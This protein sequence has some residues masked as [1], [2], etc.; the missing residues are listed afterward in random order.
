MKDSTNFLKKKWFSIWFYQFSKIFRLNKSFDNT[1]FQSTIFFCMNNFSFILMRN[2]WLIHKRSPFFSSKNRK[3][4]YSQYLSANSN[5]YCFVSFFKISFFQSS[6]SPNMKSF[7]S[8][9]FIDQIFW[10]LRLYAVKK[11]N[12]SQICSQ[13][14]T[15]SESFFLTFGIHYSNFSTLLKI[16]AKTFSLRFLILRLIQT[17]AICFFF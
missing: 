5:E 14:Q 8:L 9:K 13:N 16:R 3:I 4:K 10:F 6:F 7:D 1:A 15:I 17:Y 2:S 12:I 11:T